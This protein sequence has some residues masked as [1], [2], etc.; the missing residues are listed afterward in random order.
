MNRVRVI[1]TA[2]DQL[3]SDE[4]LTAIKQV[5]G[6][7][8]EGAAYPLNQI[9]SPNAAE[10]FVCV[11]SRKNELAK[12]VPIE[13][14]VDIEMVPDVT[15]FIELAKIPHGRIVHIFNNSTNYAKKLVEYCLE[16][17]IDHLEFKFIPYDE[18]GDNQVAEELHKA[19]FIMGV[20][21]IVGP[22]GILQQKFKAHLNSNT[23][24]I[25]ARRVT[26]ISSACALMK[27]ITLFKHQEISVKI[28]NGMNNLNHQMQQITAVAQQLSASTQ[29]ETVAFEELSTKISQGLDSLEGVKSLSEK[30]TAAAQNIGTIVDTIRHIAGQTNLLALNAT[31]EAA[32]VGDAGRGFAVVAKEVG[33]LA[34]ESQNSSETIRRSTMEIRTVVDQITPALTRLTGE[35][36]DNKTNFSELSQVAQKE[37][38]AILE[39]FKVLGNIQAMSQELLDITLQL[40]KSE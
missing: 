30:L 33:K 13:K 14:I 22:K 7:S 16:V 5:L 23:Q 37:N 6:L 35:M 38:Q 1:A 15:F 10:L 3:I 18:I 39:I 8:I 40:N 26:N 12:L 19:V 20:E 17:G 28:T 32:R 9:P 27:W 11:S 29:G 31:I 21:T 4:T 34:T 24:I 36:S 25:A 2:G